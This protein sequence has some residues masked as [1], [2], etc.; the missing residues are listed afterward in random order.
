MDAKH[1]RRNK[2]RHDE[3]IRRAA[4]RLGL[5]LCI[6]RWGPYVTKGYVARETSYIGFIQIPDPADED[7]YRPLIDKWLKRSLKVTGY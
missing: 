5:T 6:T 7:K 2:R 4:K 3:A 1:R